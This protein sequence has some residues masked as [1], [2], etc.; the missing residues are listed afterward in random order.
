ME[1]ETKK[2][3]P[4][5]L[6]KKIVI[7]VIIAVIIIIL[8]IVIVKVWNSSVSK[9]VAGNIS[10][11]GLAIESDG[12]TFYN[13]YEKGIF[14]IKNGK[15]YQ[16]TEETAY[17]MNIVGNII[18][19]LTASSS[20]EI[21]VK[22]VETNGNSLTKIGTIHTSI[23]KI[24]VV[25]GYLYY[26]SNENNVDGIAKMDVNGNN[27]TI[28]TTANIQDFQ[29]LDNEIYFTDNI[30]N[31]YK[32]T[33]TGTELERIVSDSIVKKIQVVGKWIYYY[34]EEE[35]ALCKVKTDGTAKTIVS[36]LVKSESFNVTSKK[37]YFLDTEN[38]EIASINLNGDGYKK[39]VT[40]Q[41]NKTKINIADDEMYYLDAS[42]DELQIYQMYRVKTSGNSTNPIE[43]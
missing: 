10:N 5:K 21:D 15:E 25:D 31:L 27:K 14:K 2:K 35:G 4:L 26:Y 29:V 43:Y 19:Y 6:D 22:K 39:I 33:T 18:Y 13:K 38:K 41:S 40:I 11:M 36:V 12:V 8:L 23:S 9:N 32:M 1:V 24:Y 37:I 17:S 42:Q 16:I 30:N 7:S 3:N 20:G 28:I 34:D